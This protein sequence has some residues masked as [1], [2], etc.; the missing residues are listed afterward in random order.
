MSSVKIQD[1]QLFLNHIVVFER[2]DGLPKIVVYSLPDIGEP[3]R[4][5][6]GGRAVDFT[7]ATYSVDASESEFSSS[8]LRFCY[9]S[10]KTPPSTY[11]YDMKT[12]VSILKKVE[13]VSS[14]IIMV[15]LFS[16]KIGIASRVK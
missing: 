7:D 14:S 12:G 15:M 1:I 3:L 4:S 11:D 13:T 16:L 5:L 10:M 2:E 8:V 9:S 6:E